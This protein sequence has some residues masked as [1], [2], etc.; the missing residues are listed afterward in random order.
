MPYRFLDSES[1]ETTVQRIAREQVDRVLASVADADADV[2]ETVHEAR[3][4]CKRIRGLIRLVRP[5]FADTYRRE[6]VWYRDA[7]RTLSELRDA[8]SILDTCD[9][10]ARD[11][12]TADQTPAFAKVRRGLTER[13]RLTADETG[14]RE[15]LAQFRQL[16]QQ[17]RDRIRGWKLDGDGFEV[18]QSGLRKSYKRGRAGMARA[19]RDPDPDTF[20]EWRKRVKYHWYHTRL[21]RSLW[22]GP[23]RARSR[24]IHALADCLGTDHDLAVL[25]ETLAERPQDFGGPD[26]VRTVT[27]LSRRRQTELRG[28]ART[29][30]A[31]VFTEKPEALIARLEGWWNAWQAEQRPDR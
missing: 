31:R 15:R 10:L 17:G 16:L 12:C 29:L 4:R 9:T 11:R 13:R 26:V 7:A 22:E 19:Y 21:L 5:A 24:E 25:K 8:Q 20:H 14:A 1:V 18:V 23:V 27:E 2:H 28:Q 3:K 30:G 6:N